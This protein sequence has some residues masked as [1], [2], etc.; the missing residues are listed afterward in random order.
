MTVKNRA[1]TSF[2]ARP[3]TE[4]L[5]QVLSCLGPGASVHRV[6][7]V[8]ICFDVLSG[9]MGIASLM[10]V[11]GWF[12]MVFV[13]I[14]I[15]IW[16]SQ[17]C[18]LTHGPFCISPNVQDVFPPISD[19]GCHGML[20]RKIK[21][22][23]SEGEFGKRGEEYVAAQAAGSLN[24]FFCWPCEGLRYVAHISQCGQISMVI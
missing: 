14:A 21:D 2:S 15:S 7:Q 8:A 22:T 13:T 17:S 12:L 9:I 4:N 24:P 1:S 3:A 11:V 5:D 23:I 6:I 10:G 18:G 19:N 20:L 16:K